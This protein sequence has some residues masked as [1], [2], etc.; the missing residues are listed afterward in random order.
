[1]NRLSRSRQ[2]PDLLS[3]VPL[4]MAEQPI[5][6][7]TYNI[8]FLQDNISEARAERIRAVIAALDA[9]VIG[10]Q[11][12]ADR[13]A[14]ERVFDPAQWALVIDDDSDDMQDV[15][16]AVR[17]DKLNVV[18]LNAD[19]DDL[20]ADDDDFLFPTS[21]SNY[22][23]PNRRDVLV[24]Q[25]E[26]PT[27]KARLHVMVVHAKSRS[28]GRSATDNRREGAARDLV[29]ALEQKYDDANVVIVGDFNDNPDD[30]SLNILEMGDPNAPAGPEQI[31]GP[32]LINLTEPLVVDDHVSW[33]LRADNIVDGQ[34]D[35]QVPG[36]A[37]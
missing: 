32:F 18:G 1:M 4:A 25:V 36:A 31:E 10:L 19:A 33:G 28:G 13:A 5:R 23:F 24:V 37:R 17:S 27:T 16:L 12:I 20:D 35:T 9:D 11:E 21:Q 14:L 34:I 15:A 22:F 3:G 30:R 8:W 2:H 7:A 29:E 6:I 26:E